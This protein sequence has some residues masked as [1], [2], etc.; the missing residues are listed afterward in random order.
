M[1]LSK[2]LLLPAFTVLVVIATSVSP[3]RAD[4]FEKL[5]LTI[6]GAA[7]A[8]PTPASFPFPGAIAGLIGGDATGTYSE[9]LTALFD[10]SGTPIG[11]LGVATFDF[12][13]GDT[14]TTQNL[15]LITGASPDGSTL[16]VRSIGVITGAT[17]ELS[18]VEGGFLS[19]ST[20]NALTFEFSTDV[21]L[22]LFDD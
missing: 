14:I 15:S 17:G 5:N 18:G 22:F 8:L 19:S 12:G 4:G 1:R 20:V 2:R 9:T 10:G 6:D 16:F 21:K 3:A 7:S 11:T 13:E